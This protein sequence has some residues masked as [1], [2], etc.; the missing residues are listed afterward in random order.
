MASFGPAKRSHFWPPKIGSWAHFWAFFGGILGHENRPVL[1]RQ[2]GQFRVQ[3][4]DPFWELQV[5]VLCSS[6]SANM[7]QFWALNWVHLWG[8]SSFLGNQT[9]VLLPIWAPRFRFWCLFGSASTICSLSFGFLPPP[10]LLT[11]VVAFLQWENCSRDA[12]DTPHLS[13]CTY[14]WV[15]LHSS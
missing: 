2:S 13:Q 1:G 5:L 6:L 9:L 14:L 7:D 10:R 11:K 12:D 4:L 3:I 15:T 8:S